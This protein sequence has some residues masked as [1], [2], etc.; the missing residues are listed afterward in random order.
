MNDIIFYLIAGIGIESLYAMLGASLV[1]VYRGSGV[2]NFAVGDGD[3]R[4]HVRPGVEPGRDLPSV[5]R[6]PAHRLAEPARA[7]HAQRHRSGCQWRSPS[8]SP[9]PWPP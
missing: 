7:D 1:V 3:V 6:H 5:G 8:S 4:R 9:S 2:I